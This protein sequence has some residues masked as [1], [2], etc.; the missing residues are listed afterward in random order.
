[1]SNIAMAEIEKA[2]DENRKRFDDARMEK[3]MVEERKR[4]ADETDKYEAQITEQN[5][6]IYKKSLII[7]VLGVIIAISVIVLIYVSFD[8]MKRLGWFGD[9]KKS[10]YMNRLFPDMQMAYSGNMYNNMAPFTA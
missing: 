6:E 3:T 7:T 10:K 2:R 8:Y 1:M 5:S 4:I 9:S